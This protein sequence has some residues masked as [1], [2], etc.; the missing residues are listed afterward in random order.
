MGISDTDLD[1]LVEA[2]VIDRPAA[3]RIAA[4]EARRR[5]V[6]SG[7]P[8]LQELA[9]Y[10]GA[11]VIGVGVTVLAATNWQHLGAGGRLAS[12]GVPAIAALAVGYVLR[13][14]PNPGLRR[15]A[16]VA[17]F[18]A[19]ALIT[20][21]VAVA[22]NEAGWAGETVTLVA[23]LVAAPVAI[24]LWWFS[25]VDLQVVGIGAA[26]F[27]LSV[28]ITARFGGDSDAAVLLFGSS[29]TGAG[30]L[31]LIATET[32]VLVPRLTARLLSGAALAVGSFYAGLP[33]APSVGAL[34]ALTVTILLVV[35]SIRFTTLLY[36][37]FAVITAFAG[38]VTLILRHVHNPTLAA[39]A[40]I[41]VGIAM[42]IAIAV[43][44]KVRP[45]RG[46]GSASTGGRWSAGGP[47]RWLSGHA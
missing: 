25:R 20:A 30:L 40:L 47:R 37:V 31:G 28:A 43:I 42:L 29:L 6:E 35:A 41:V 27:L 24:A 32:G 34:L 21:T 8:G 26:L 5:P 23:G 3:D 16:S 17:W 9:S 10:L 13:T 46:G 1:R 2:G 15:A 36:T 19:A 22:G 12:P 39:L 45:W 14:S 4:F 44:S 7:R 18:L 33:P 38:L 11:A